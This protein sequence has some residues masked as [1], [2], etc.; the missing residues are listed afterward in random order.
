M[1]GAERT[2]DLNRPLRAG[3]G[4]RVRIKAFKNLESLDGS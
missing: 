1:C 4:D 3:V 2:L